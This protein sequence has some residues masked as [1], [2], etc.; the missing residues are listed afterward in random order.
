[1]SRPMLRSRGG[2]KTNVEVEG[3]CQDQCGGRGAVSRPMLRS[4]G[5][6][7]TNVEVE[8]WCQNHC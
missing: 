8:G 6:V 7:N 3:R 4:R 1:M 2:A 5:G